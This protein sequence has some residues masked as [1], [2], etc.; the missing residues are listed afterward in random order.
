[1]ES[2]Y[3][4]FKKRL[5]KEF[6]NLDIKKIEVVFQIPSYFDNCKEYSGELFWY[7]LLKIIS[8][9]IK[10][11]LGSII[12]IIKGQIYYYDREL[13]SQVI[14]ESNN[15]DTLFKN[16]EED[17]IIIKQL[18]QKLSEGKIEKEKIE[19]IIL[20]QLE[21]DKET[22]RYQLEYLKKLKNVKKEN[23]NQDNTLYG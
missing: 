8:N 3:E 2:Y 7:T 1:M 4:K 15:I 17:Y 14:E 19:K 23:K 11:N 5:S 16:A 10:W 20:N 12:S 22:T 21:I 13:F 9:I 18:V 6:P